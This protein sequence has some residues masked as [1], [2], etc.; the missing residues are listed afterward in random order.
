MPAQSQSQ[1]SATK[2]DP[3]DKTSE[4]QRGAEEFTGLGSSGHGLSK[5]NDAN[6]VLC[7][8][9]RTLFRKGTY[10]RCGNFSH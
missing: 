4:P 3:K 10:C 1:T 8:R 5:P 6:M 7:G 2:L 9:C